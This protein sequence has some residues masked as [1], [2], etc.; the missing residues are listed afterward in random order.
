[1]QSLCAGSLFRG[2]NAF[3]NA[4][5]CVMRSTWNVCHTRV[6]RATVS[7]VVEACEGRA[8][9]GWDGAAGGARK[10]H[11]GTKHCRYQPCGIVFALTDYCK[12]H[13]GS[14]KD[15]HETTLTALEHLQQLWLE[16]PSQQHSIR[17]EEHRQARSRRPRRQGH[18]PWWLQGSRC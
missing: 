12:K 13:T 8:G 9:N 15:A 17:G 14:Q 4:R 16:H 5:I 6:M 7:N 1:M 2:H 18:P 10:H 11:V 3:Q